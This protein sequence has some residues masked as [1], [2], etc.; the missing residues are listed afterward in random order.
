MHIPFYTG[1]LVIKNTTRSAQTNV[2]SGPYTGKDAML[3]NTVQSGKRNHYHSINYRLLSISY[4]CF[5]RNVYLIFSNNIFS[6]H[7]NVETKP[8]DGVHCDNLSSNGST[9]YNLPNNY[10]SK[11]LCSVFSTPIFTKDFDILIL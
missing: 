1:Q 7:N 10:T 11:F 3:E 2:S 5:K 9:I 4:L 8:E 6:R